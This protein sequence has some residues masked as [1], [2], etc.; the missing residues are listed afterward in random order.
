MTL[1]DWRDVEQE[2][3]RRLNEKSR[4]VQSGEPKYEYAPFLL[5][6]WDKFRSGG[7]GG[8]RIR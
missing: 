1:N 5:F 8:N 4:T 6:A 3:K 7:A 2:V